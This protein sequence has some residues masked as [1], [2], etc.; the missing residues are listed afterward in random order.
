MDDDPNKAVV[1]PSNLNSMKA[2]LV[3]GKDV[4]LPRKKSFWKNR[5]GFI[6]CE[7]C[8]A[9]LKAIYCPEIIVYHLAVWTIAFGLFILSF[10]SLIQAGLLL[11]APITLIFFEIAQTIN[12]Q[13]EKSCF[14]GFVQVRRQIVL[15]DAIHAILF[16]GGII[17]SYSA[18]SI[19]QGFLGAYG[20]Y[21]LIELA[22]YILI[23]YSNS[24]ITGT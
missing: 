8:G 6:Q 12:H 4:M 17:G 7:S 16:I 2:C 20:L 13:I 18:M 10:V 5:H 22:R 14:R 9:E 11:L 15:L 1:L 3:C 21:C 19:L 23:K 24:R